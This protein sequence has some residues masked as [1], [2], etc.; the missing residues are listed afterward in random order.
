MPLIEVSWGEEKQLCSGEQLCAL[1]KPWLC[2]YTWAPEQSPQLGAGGIRSEL[3]QLSTTSRVKHSAA[4]IQV[5]NA[6]PGCVRVPVSGSQGSGRALGG[7]VHCRHCPLAA[8]QLLE[9]N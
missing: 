4:E 7:K 3:L 6:S 1:G 2:A 9:E 8:S 5:S